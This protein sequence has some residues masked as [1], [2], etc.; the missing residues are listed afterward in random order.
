MDDEK[1]QLRS[2]LGRTSGIANSVVAAAL[3]LMLILLTRFASNQIQLAPNVNATFSSAS[4]LPDSGAL[5]TFLRDVADATD[6]Q[7]RWQTETWSETHTWFY[8]SSTFANS[9]ACFFLAAVLARIYRTHS[10]TSYAKLALLFCAF[11]LSGGIAH[12]LEA[13]MFWW[14]AYRLTTLAITAEGL[15]LTASVAAMIRA[16]PQLMS[17]RSSAEIQQEI[18]QRRRTE[19]E[20]R[21]VH[22]Q[23]EGVIEQRTAELASKNEEMEQF[24]NTVSHD[25][26]SPIVTCLG[27]VTS[28][29]EDMQAGRLDDSNDTIN[30]IERSATR[31]R[32]LIEDLLNLSRIGKVRFEL[33]DV[34]A[35]AILRSICEEFKPRIAK[36]NVAL[37]IETS[38]P[39]LH[40]D[41]HWLTEVFENLITNAIKYG[42]DN[43]QPRI[44]VGCVSD[45]KEHRFYVRDNG[46]GIDPANHAKIFEPFR[47]LQTEKEGS[48][49][50][51]TIV[52]RIVKM[53]GGRIWI[54]SQVGHGA[55]FW[56][57]LP[58]AASQDSSQARQQQT[59]Q[60]EPILSGALH[61]A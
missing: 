28:L 52:V 26:K 9:A 39:H 12:L 18:V 43:A 2:H 6:F 29:R 42:C 41:P 33:A 36:L 13:L 37:E 47:R 53:H 56:I 10:A 3:M 22:T 38:L 34:D 50:G 16:A 21:K 8:I 58:V 30:R 55:T 60:G 44:T 51:L 15:I 57:A 7:P 17:L 45:E 46:R 32:R 1:N 31:M 27:L 19:L 35:N 20:L 49:M 54:D 48:G 4:I 25:L 24:L 23:L 5:F 14:P 11:F 40:A 59:Q 61:A